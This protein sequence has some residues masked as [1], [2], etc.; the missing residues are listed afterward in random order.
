MHWH[1]HKVGEGRSAEKIHST[2]T[3][4]RACIVSLCKFLSRMIICSNRF[5]TNAHTTCCNITTP[6]N[7]YYVTIQ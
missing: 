5:D 1:L 3:I 4:K 7:V 6:T 2:L